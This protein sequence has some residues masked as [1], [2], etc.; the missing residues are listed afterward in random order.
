MCTV[1]VILSTGGQPPAA[2]AQTDYC[3][4][5]CSSSSNGTVTCY[6][7]AI[8]TCSSNCSITPQYCDQCR[9]ESPTSSARTTATMAACTAAACSTRKFNASLISF[10]SLCDFDYNLATII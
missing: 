1:L 7:N 5:A 2:A 10:Y 8:N 6:N 3:A 4:T 9:R